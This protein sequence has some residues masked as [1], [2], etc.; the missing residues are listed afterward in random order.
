MLQLNNIIGEKTI[1][2]DYPILGKEVAV[3]NMFSGNIQYKFTEPR[4]IELGLRNKRVRAGIYTRS[5]LRRLR[6]DL[7][8]PKFESQKSALL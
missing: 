4:E 2:L 6:S 3:V 8:N 7:L 5:D 1:D